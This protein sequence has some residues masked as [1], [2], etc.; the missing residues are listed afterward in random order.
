MKWK[1]VLAVSLILSL[2]FAISAFSQA[3]AQAQYSLGLQGVTWN[4]STLSVLVIPQEGNSWWK[5]SYLN[6]TLRAIGEWNN[7]ILDFASNYTNFAYLSRLRMVPTISHA[8]NSSFDV[9]IS[10][11]KMPFSKDEIGYTT[12]WHEV[13]SGII[14]NS[15]ISLAAEDL[16]GDVLNE[17][18]MQNVALHELGH[19]LG[20]GHSNYSG[21]VM[22]P[23]Y[24]LN[25]PVEG[26]STLDLYGVSTV[27]QWMSDSSNTPYSPQQSSVTLPS[28][29]P[30]QYL[31]ISYADLPPV[32]QSPSPSQTQTLLTNILTLLTSILRFI[33]RPE[34]LIPLLIAISALLVTEILFARL[35][36]AKRTT[37]DENSSVTEFSH[38]HADT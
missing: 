10:W 2:M 11:T 30:Y 8:I 9:Y 4:H 21:D 13:P 20:L 12:T 7:A 22:Y 15:T 25:Q 26:L 16:R 34:L 29:I 33:L 6:A 27:F 24:T 35:Q 37:R 5:S 3:Q 28:S 14:T 17:V 36:K 23:T 32:S 31:P 18:D 19:G 38:G 1:P